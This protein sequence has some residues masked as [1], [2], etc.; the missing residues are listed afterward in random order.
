MPLIKS[1]FKLN[2]FILLPLKITVRFS[3]LWYFHAIANREGTKWT[4]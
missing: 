4:C 3:K 1:E 2:Y